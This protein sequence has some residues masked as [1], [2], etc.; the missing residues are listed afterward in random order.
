MPQIRT[1]AGML[2]SPFNPQPWLRPRWTL[3]FLAWLLVL[4]PI[5]RA[6]RPPLRWGTV[7]EMERDLARYGPDTTAAVVILYDYGVWTPQNFDEGKVALRHH[8]RYKVLRPE[9][10]HV[11]EQAIDLPPGE[12]LKGL[13]AQTIT[14]ENG[15]RQVH[16]L[17]L[18]LLPPLPLPDGGKRY[19][20]T[21]PEVQPGA[22]LEYTYLRQSQSWESLHPWFFQQPY[23]VLW[24]EVRLTG[25]EPYRYLTAA[26]PV[27]H[28]PQGYQRWI[29]K[30]VP[31]W[32]EAPYRAGDA[33]RKVLHFN[34]YYPGE[35]E[36]SIPGITE[37]SAQDMQRQWEQLSQNLDQDSRLYEDPDKLEAF[38][39]LVNSLI[40]GATSE[41]EIA[42]R[43]HAHLRDYLQ[44][45]GTYSARVSRS[46]SEI[47][48]GRRAHSG[49]INMLLIQLLYQA[50]LDVHKVFVPTVGQGTPIT[51][52]AIR[53]Q[54]DHLIAQVSV[55]GQWRLLDATA[56]HLPASLLPPASL[57]Q[58]GWVIRPDTMGWI[59]LPHPTFD[60]TQATVQLQWPHP[61]SL[62]HADV[63]LTYQGYA[64]GRLR[65]D[66]LQAE[67]LGTLL[68]PGMTLAEPADVRGRD[69]LG[70]PLT[71]GASLRGPSPAGDSA[72]GYAF[73]LGKMVT[74]PVPDL[75][76][77]P[78]TAPVYLETLSSWEAAI[79]FFIPPGYQVA[80][81]PKSRRVTLPNQ[82]AVFELRCEGGAGLVLWQ[83]SG[84]I[85]Y[86]HFPVAYYEALREWV[87]AVQETLAQP[88]VLMPD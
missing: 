81:L 55:D 61:D 65:R 56:A 23:P 66:G 57:N 82:E 75:P 77:G 41:A 35:D 60:L 28:P 15:K 44:W 86:R 3:C 45:D 24:S 7:S 62:V 42:N 11:A 27:A 14:F 2:V 29:A 13:Q 39:Q 18:R 78:R 9:G 10:V 16:K 68:P 31:A 70:A 84:R 58:L 50:G 59:R 83:V 30:Y 72:G 46:P 64:A 52:A 69:S 63:N 54:F 36:V 4:S 26:R 6:Q 80:R 38:Q 49:E 21:F 74:L 34:L 85:G 79:S 73:G 47:Y 22:I 51:E 87:Q 88:L 37:L 71:I 20:F 19:T 5:L 8:R 12:L 67:A 76:P 25:F 43:L 33:G 53:D 1:F 48:Y 17:K 40:R 32:T